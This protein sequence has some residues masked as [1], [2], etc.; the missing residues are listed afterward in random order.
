MDIR[1]I[2]LA[3]EAF[4]KLGRPLVIIGTGR[5]KKKLQRMAKRNIKFVGSISE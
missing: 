3:V 5:E 4:N 2:Q 1:R